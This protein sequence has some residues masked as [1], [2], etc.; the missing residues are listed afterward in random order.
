VNAKLL[1][2]AFLLALVFVLAFASVAQA[3]G[4][5]KPGNVKV[6]IRDAIDGAKID[7]PKQFPLRVEAYQNGKL[8]D[9]FIMKY[10]SSIKRTWPAGKFDLK[11]I[12]ATSH[13]TLANCGPYY[14]T[15]TRK[16]TIWAYLIDNKT[17]ACKL[18]AK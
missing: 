8:A 3:A 17:A 6:T 7:L 13:T 15:S 5:I 4:H 10:P 12:D 11:L 14:L 9:H 1:R 18:L 2:N 16:F